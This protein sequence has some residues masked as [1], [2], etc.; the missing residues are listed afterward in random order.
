MTIPREWLDR[1][2]TVAEVEVDLAADGPPDL[3][4]RQWRRLVEAMAAG[5]ELWGYWHGELGGDDAL[6][7]TV[8]AV[9][10]FEPVRSHL[11]LEQVSLADPLDRI[12]GE[13]AGYAVIRDGAIVDWIEA[14]PADRW[15]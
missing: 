13:R 5:D 7:G 10:G 9:A 14:P 12:V 2:T 4:L 1:E 3:W 6:G 15:S 11:A 8:A